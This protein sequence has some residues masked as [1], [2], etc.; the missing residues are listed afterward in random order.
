M[1]RLGKI[2]RAEEILQGLTQKEPAYGPGHLALAKMDYTAGRFD[3]AVIGFRKFQYLGPGDPLAGL[4]P[5]QMQYTAAMLLGRSLTKTNQL[6]P[7]QAAYLQAEKIKPDDPESR[8][9]LAELALAVGKKETA[10][11]YAART[12]E[13]RPG[14]RRAEMILEK[15]IK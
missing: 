6:E 11:H 7:A 10:R 4:S 1:D 15:V 8:L 12:L 14:N 13:L 9:A 3:R 2:A 5:T